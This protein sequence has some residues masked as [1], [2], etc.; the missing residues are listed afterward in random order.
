MPEFPDNLEFTSRGVA[1]ATLG[2]LF[3]SGAFLVT[4]LWDLAALVGL[5]VLKHLTASSGRIFL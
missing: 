2:A 3:L 5:E 4:P 1:L